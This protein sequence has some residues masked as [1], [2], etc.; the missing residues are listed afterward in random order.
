[1]FS[2]CSELT[3]RAHIPDTR[4]PQLMQPWE[5]DGLGGPTNCMLEQA[6]PQ[7]VKWS[8]LSNKLYSSVSWLTNECNT[9]PNDAF[10][11][12][13]WGVGTRP[14]HRFVPMAKK[15]IVID[16]S[17]YRLENLKKMHYIWSVRPIFYWFPQCPYAN[18][19]DKEYFFE[20]YCGIDFNDLFPSDIL[21]S[22]LIVE[23]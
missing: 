17:Y 19:S 22:N 10:S 15:S 21:F 8:K 23:L 13:R 16:F 5:Q 3:P 7:I 2:M 1:M 4:I 14:G 11:P 12:V 6:V 18:F 9:P 20:N